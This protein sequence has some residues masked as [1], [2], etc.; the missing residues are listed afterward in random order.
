M[1][2]R[3]CNGL[4]LVHTGTRAQKHTFLVAADS[5]AELCNQTVALVADAAQCM[6]PHTMILPREGWEGQ[7]H[8][9]TPAAPLV[10]QY[11][12]LGGA[13]FV[14]LDRTVARGGPLTTCLSRTCG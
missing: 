13:E 4:T 1:P 6:A 7:H 2:W 3:G 8:T 12:E 10:A 11:V 5:E 14:Y 9:Q